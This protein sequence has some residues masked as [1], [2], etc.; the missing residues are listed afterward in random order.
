MFTTQESEAISWQL[1]NVLKLYM[2]CEFARKP[3]SLALVKLWKATKFRNLLLYIGPVAFKSFL[4]KDLYNH[5][6]VLH[7]AIRILCFS[8]LQDYIDYAH[9][10]RQHLY[11]HSR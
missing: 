11:H 6:L 1:E 3:R 4:Q 10:L 8:K 9:N 5:F 2:P 7:V